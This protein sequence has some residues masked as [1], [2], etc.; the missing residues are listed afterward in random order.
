[1]VAGIVIPVGA[2]ALEFVVDK[3][4]KHRFSNYLRVGVATSAIVATA[5]IIAKETKAVFAY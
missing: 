4:V 5:I 2:V 1:M 3:Y